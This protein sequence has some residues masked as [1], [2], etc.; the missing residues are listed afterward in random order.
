MTVGG[1][2]NG[3]RMRPGLFPK[4]HRKMILLDEFHHMTNGPRDQNVMVHLQSARDEGKVSALKVYGDLKLQ[5]AVR[6]ITVGNYANRRRRT[7]QYLCQHL[8]LFY[9]VP[10]ALSRMDFAWCV[11]EPVKMVP[12]EVPHYWTPELAR[13]L[14]LRA[15]ALEPHQVHLADDAVAMAKQVAMEWDAIYA[16]DDLALHT[17]IEKHHSIIRIAIAIANICY[18]HPALSDLGG[19]GV[20]R[21]YA[22]LVDCTY[23]L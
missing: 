18:A 22:F 9:G 16:A 1:A 13:A 7:F 20:F 23:N 3:S 21:P 5:A 19:G 4:N 11:H 10:E 14:I 12:E 15:W 8:L 6:L 17:G 2:E